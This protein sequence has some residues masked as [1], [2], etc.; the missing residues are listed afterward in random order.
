M[1]MKEEKKDHNK[2]KSK[3]KFKIV[4]LKKGRKIKGNQNNKNPHSE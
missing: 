2:Y 4:N 3:T 1:E